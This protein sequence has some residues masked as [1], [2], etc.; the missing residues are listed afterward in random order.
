MP[1]VF[2]AGPAMS[3][4]PKAVLLA[5]LGAVVGVCAF[6]S[7]CIYS[8]ISGANAAKAKYLSL[9]RGPKVEM[10]GA[11]VP[12]LGAPLSQAGAGGGGD[13]HSV[14]YGPFVLILRA[15]STDFLVRPDWQPGRD[16][17]AVRESPQMVLYFSGPPRTWPG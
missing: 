2:T 5:M 10:C 14:C 13:D 7:A 9:A 6:W 12:G 16:T 3:R 4:M 11:V 17:I 15:G 8:E 1:S